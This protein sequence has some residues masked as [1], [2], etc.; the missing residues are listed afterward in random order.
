MTPSLKAVRQGWGW[1]LRDPGYAEIGPRTTLGNF[2]RKIQKSSHILK[3]ILI[4]RTQCIFTLT[5]KKKC[6][7]K[8]EILGLG[9]GCH[10]GLT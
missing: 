9:V 10:L 6:F 4:I 3:T 7:S 2:K 5:F 1:C 8:G